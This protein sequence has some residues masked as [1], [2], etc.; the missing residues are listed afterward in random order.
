VAAFDTV[1]SMGADSG[2][3]EAVLL[4]SR[5]LVGVA[6]KSLA[7][8]EN[9]VS[10]MQWRVLVLVA[11]RPE[12]TLQDLASKLGV[13]PSTGTRLCDQLVTKR[14]ITRREHPTDR[15]FLVLNL[16]AK[17]RLLVKKVSDDRRQHIEE[18]LADMPEATRGLLVRVLSDFAAAAGEVVIDPLWDLALTASGEPQ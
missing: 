15:R 6:A 9:V 10:A 16:T 11:G 1:P 12:L 17:G 7:Q 5:A 8:V 2:D 14:L 4:A 18:I 3:S 13:H